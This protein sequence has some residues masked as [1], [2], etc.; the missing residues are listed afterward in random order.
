MFGSARYC[1]TTVVA[2][3]ASDEL[4]ASSS[5]YQ[6]TSLLQFKGVSQMALR[7]RAHHLNVVTATS[8][9]FF[10]SAMTWLHLKQ[11]SW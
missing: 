10:Q 7:L 9:S 1:S 6:N 4:P 8:H 11:Q 2:V 3:I 5:I